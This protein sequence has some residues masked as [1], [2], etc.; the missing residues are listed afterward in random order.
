MTITLNYICSYQTPRK[1]FKRNYTYLNMYKIKN[2]GIRT[3]LTS[4]RKGTQAMDLAKETFIKFAN[5]FKDLPY[6]SLHKDPEVIAYFKQITTAQ[7][8][9]C[10]RAFQL[11]L[12][13]TYNKRNFDRTT[14]LLQFENKFSFKAIW[15]RYNLTSTIDQSTLFS[16]LQSDIVK[17]QYPKLDIAIQ[18]TPPSNVSI[19]ELNSSLNNML[20]EN[21]KFTGNRFPDITLN[22]IPYDYKFVEKISL[23]SN[24]ILIMPASLEAVTLLS[25]HF[26][27]LI[28]YYK[29][30]HTKISYDDLVYNKL[31]VLEKE[32]KANPT[33]AVAQGILTHWND[34]LIQTMEQRPQQWGVPLFIIS[35]NCYQVDTSY[36]NQMKNIPLREGNLDQVRA[37][38]TLLAIISDYPNNIKHAVY[39]ATKGFLGEPSIPTTSTEILD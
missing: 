19:T 23:T 13:V 8:S 37:K 38:E 28:R 12:E 22:G 24:H 39:S 33:L 1:N 7:N 10:N 4:V 15:D 17:N 6:G 2:I 36:L 5:H 31:L 27:Y 25:S 26:N 34:F 18:Q 35:K 32:L 21:L 30:T 11:A 3:M 29:R 14:L 16:T 9:L 20:E